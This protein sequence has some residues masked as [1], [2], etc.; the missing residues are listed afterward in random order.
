MAVPPIGSVYQ[1]YWPAEAPVAV[2][3]TLEFPQADAPV[4]PGGPGIVL[5]VA[6]TMVRLLSQVPLFMAT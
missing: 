3:V 5:M 6:V 1:R 2:S 4:V